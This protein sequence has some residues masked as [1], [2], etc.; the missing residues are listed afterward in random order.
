MKYK[1]KHPTERVLIFII[2][3]I[4]ALLAAILWV[5]GQKLDILWN[6]QQSTASQQTL[7]PDFR[8]AIQSAQRVLY[9]PADVD[10]A[11]NRVYFPGLKIYVPLTNKSETLIYTNQLESSTPVESIVSARSISD[12]YL[13][14][15]DDLKCLVKPAGVSVDKPSGA[16]KESEKAGTVKLGDGRTLYLYKTDASGCQNIYAYVSPGDIIDSLKQAMSY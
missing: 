14:N 11:A 13:N 4:I 15:F 12:N 16:W 2:V 3:A 8:Q 10:A 1:Y 5:Y 7:T 6:E 9:N